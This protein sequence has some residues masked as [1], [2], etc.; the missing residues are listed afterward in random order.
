GCICGFTGSSGDIDGA[1]VFDRHICAGFFR[2]GVDGLALRA[3][4]LT[5]LGYWNLDRGDLRCQW[6]HLIWSVNALGHDVQDLFA[7]IACLRQSISQYLGWDAIQLGIQL[8]C[9]DVVAGTRDLEVHIAECVF[10]T[11]DIGQS[12]EALFTVDLAGDKT[13][14]NTSNRCLQRDASVVQRHRRSTDR[15]HG[16]RT[17]GSKSLRDLANGVRE[18]LAWRDD[19]QQ[20]TLCECTVAN[21]AALWRTNT[22]GFTGGVWREVVVVDITLGLHWGQRVNGLL[23]LEHIQGGHTKNLG[24]TALKQRRAVY[25]WDQTNLSAQVTDIFCRTTI[26]TET[27]GEDLLTHDFPH[28]LV[29]SS[30]DLLGRII[31]GKDLEQL[32]FDFFHVR[33]RSFV[34]LL[35]RSNGHQLA[36]LLLSLACNRVVDLVSVWREKLEFLRFLRRAL[37]KSCLCFTQSL[38][39]WLGCFES[40]C[41]SGLLR[42][43]CAFS[44]AFVHVHASACFNHHDG[45]VVDVFA[46]VLAADNTA[47]N[48]HFKQRTLVLF[49]IRECQPLA[50]WVLI[51]SQQCHADTADRARYWQT[52]KLGCSRR[53]VD[54]DDVVVFRWVQAQDGIDDL[55]LI[56]QALNE[57]RAQR[58]V[59]QTTRQDGFS[60]WAGFATEERAGDFTCGIHA[61]FHI[62]GQ[63]EEIK[64][65][66]RLVG[67]SHG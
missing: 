19:R 13:H 46:L 33:I 56:A 25:A 62:H 23:H 43:W 44:N 40:G 18:L 2:D 51:I 9:G 35:L 45:N 29:V 16:S 17:I 31:F 8:Q 38:D 55:N 65:F 58:A 24:F 52:G 7:G 1:V 5:D 26:D 30:A 64:S 41:N 63:R 20:R 57:G 54:G 49:C 27:F 59:N 34:A 37:S 48:D 66:A 28:Q 14:R 47:G 6:R 50:F 3:N 32:C 11:Q 53:A 21:L 36:E 4:Q 22:T 61:F 67:C 15:T 42:R 39:E 60:R 10:C 12:D